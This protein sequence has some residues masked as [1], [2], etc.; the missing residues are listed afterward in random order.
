MTRPDLTLH[1]FSSVKGGVGKSTLTVACAKVLQSA[2]R[3]C[4]VI[5]LDLTGTSLMD[6]L[7][8]CAPR[9]PGGGFYSREETLRLRD[10]RRISTLDQP[11]RPPR[12]VN[13]LFLDL[14]A[15]GV[16]D[17]GSGMWSHAED[18]GA[19]Y[20]PA[21]SLPAHVLLAADWFAPVQQD[22]WS[23]LLVRLLDRLT[24]ELPHLTDVVLDLPS[25]MHGFA[26]RALTVVSH[27]ARGEPLPAGHP[28][29]ADADRR[30]TVHP[31]L[32]T[33][34]D[35][36]D[37]FAA[38]ESLAVLSPALP[39]LRVLVNR[40]RSEPIERVRARV[41]DRFGAT[42]IEEALEGLHERESSLGRVFRDGRL[43]VGAEDR[44]MLNRS[45]LRTAQ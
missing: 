8:L 28:Q 35:R 39:G 6:G 42:G 25:G 19:R 3:S 26:Y 27:L 1:V 34:P 24:R 23:L 30:W 31:F 2:G 20:L 36:N 14:S 15:D 29:L 32:V 37:L 41:V 5:D 7:D 22:E 9:E 16:F 21:S 17:V 11:P 40:M 43:V 44:T 33:S 13:D 10:A 18:D 12:F 4:A 45:F 38:V